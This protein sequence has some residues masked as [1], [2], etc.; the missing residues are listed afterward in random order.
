MNVSSIIVK[1]SIENMQDV[2][3]TINAMEYCETHFS[4]PEGKIVVTIEGENID[5][6]MAIMKE[7][8]NISF[9]HGASL[10]YSYCEEEL[11]DSLDKI[12]KQTTLY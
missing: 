9:V 10:A 12:K 4:D 5:R 8:L 2:T 1:T 3:D 11:S 7:I 6:Q